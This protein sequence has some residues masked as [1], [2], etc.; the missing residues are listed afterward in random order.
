VASKLPTAE[1]PP[2]LGDPTAAAAF[3]PA[4]GAPTPVAPVPGAPGIGAPGIGS[5]GPKK[6]KPSSTGR[7]GSKGKPSVKAKS[8]SRSSLSGQAGRQEGAEGR[9]DAQ[10]VLSRIEPWSVMK[11]S[12]IVSLVG[13]IA[14][15]VV[16]ALLYYALRAFGVFHYLE[17]TVT[18]IT[19]GKGQAGAN[20]AAWFSASTVLGYT[21]LVGAINVVLITAITTV[22]AVVYNLITHVSGGVEVTLREA[23]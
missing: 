20:S 14:L 15:F 16:V 22:G 12:F 13:W 11:F 21:M 23:D 8:G 4:P 2:A 18:T 5:P 9:R 19:S 10:L 6:R 17:D 1:A 7:P 3:A